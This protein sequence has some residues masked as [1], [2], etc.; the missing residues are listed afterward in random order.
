M[1]RQIDCFLKG[2]SVLS[3]LNVVFRGDATIRITVY[4]LKIWV[5]RTKAA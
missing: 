3:I 2:V 1:E 4:V 5:T